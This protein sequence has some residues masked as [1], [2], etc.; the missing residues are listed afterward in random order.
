MSGKDRIRRQQILREAEG[1]LDLA[2][3]FGDDWPLTFDRR[4]CLAQKSLHVLDRLQASSADATEALMLRGQ[5]LRMLER[6]NEAIVDLRR[7][8]E[9]DPES[10]DVWLALGWCYKRSDRLDLAIE[11]LESALRSEPAAAILHYNLACYWSLAHDSDKA[12][13][14]LTQALQLNDDYRLMV[15]SEPDFDPIRLD[16]R[17]RELTAVI[18]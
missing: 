2:M 16:P 4:S 13:R 3:L 9:L 15:H 14:F 18:V 10:I 11:S 6:Y 17:F 8:A 12:I 1:Y 5:A 7:A